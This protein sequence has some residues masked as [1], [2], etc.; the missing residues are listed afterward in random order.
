[1]FVEDATTRNPEEIIKAKGWIQISDEGAIRTSNESHK[2][3][4]KSTNV[5]QNVHRRNE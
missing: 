1:M 3:Q 4:G 5:E 2:R